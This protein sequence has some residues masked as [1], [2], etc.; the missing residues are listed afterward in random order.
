MMDTKAIN[1]Y[2][3]CLQAVLKSFNKERIKEDRWR[4][5]L[6]AKRKLGILSAAYM[7]TEFK[8]MDMS[9]YRGINTTFKKGKAV[10]IVPLPCCGIIK[11]WDTGKFHYDFER[12]KLDKKT[13]VK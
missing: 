7:L 13:I 12:K 1:T 6:E 9:S 11:L 4:I 2:Y 5:S 3:G 8:R 10:K